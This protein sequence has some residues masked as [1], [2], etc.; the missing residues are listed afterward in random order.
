MLLLF[1]VLVLFIRSP[2]G[3]DILV[4]KLTK[5]VSNKTNTKVEVDRLFI[6]FSG[7]VFLEGLYL[8]DKKGDTLVHSKFL[9]ANLALFPLIFGNSLDLKALEWNGLRANI[10]RPDTSEDFNFNFLIEAFVSADT[11]PADYTSEPMQ[12][13]IGAID[14]TDISIDY[15]DGYL[16]IES[17]LRLGK[18][19]LDA[20]ETDFD[21]QVFK[22]DKLEFNNSQ[23]RYKQLKPFVATED[24]TETQLPF[25]SVDLL[26]IQNVEIDY[27][28]RPDDIL[29]N[30]TIGDF[31]LELPKADLAK[32]D[33]E[34]ALISLKNSAFSLK[35]SSNPS[36]S[37][38][39]L[40]VE[41]TATNF[42]WPDYIIAADRI[43]L[44]NNQV[45]YQSG[46]PEYAKKGF[47]ANNISISNLAIDVS[48]VS[49][50]AKKANLELTTFSFKEK[51]GFYLKNF[52][53]AGELNDA[54][55]SISNLKL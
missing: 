5:Y 27:K 8:E 19:L 55:A 24:T 50:A 25:L 29:L 20:D 2:W 23:I 53:F 47:D 48:D 42:E 45:Q 51:G 44:E 43:T 4:G 7:N 9:E 11:L 40:L 30:A 15:K 46:I 17:Q 35:S 49:Y 31:L 36:Q 26:A 41:A 22:V 52:S 37:Q 21:G 32:N 6:T 12:I 34:V 28:S 54:A 1:I 14:L 38:D 3:Q 16:G 39:S 13:D 33:V 10:N 18:L